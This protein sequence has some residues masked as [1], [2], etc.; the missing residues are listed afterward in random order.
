MWSNRRWAKLARALADAGFW[1]GLPPAEAQAQQRQVAAGGYPFTCAV[2][3]PLTFFADGEDLAEGG[4]EELLRE[5]TPALLRFGVAL[6]VETISEGDTGVAYVV[7]INGR[8]CT[9]LDD[10]DLRYNWPWFEATVR[11]LSVVNDLLH[12]AGTQTRVLTLHT[13]GNEGLALL[14]D[15][16]I[17]DIIRRSGLL[18]AGN[19]PELPAPDSAVG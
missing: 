2:L 5:M 17:V 14:L 6:Q 1:V 4:V 13:G 9:V 19:L 12:A 10:D 7:R 3:E 8:D 11:P 18:T 16:T 15:P